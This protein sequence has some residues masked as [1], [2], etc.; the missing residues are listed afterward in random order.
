M[1]ALQLWTSNSLTQPFPKHEISWLERIIE[2]WQRQ[3]NVILCPN[4][5]ST[6][7]MSLRQSCSPMSMQN[8]SVLVSTQNA[9]LIVCCGWELA[10]HV[11]VQQ[12]KD[13]K[14]GIIT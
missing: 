4:L 12:L 13:V 14:I 6:V 1:S 9:C 8:Q 3:I 7:I 2:Q 11:G 5:V 10:M